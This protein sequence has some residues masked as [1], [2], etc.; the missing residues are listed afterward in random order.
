M[1]DVR[2]LEA[3]LRA[4]RRSPLATCSASR[5]EQSSTPPQPSNRR[6]DDVDLD[7]TQPVEMETEERPPGAIVCTSCGGSQFEDGSARPA[8]PSSR[9]GATTSP[10]HHP[11][12]SGV[13]DKG[14]A[15]RNEDAAMAVVG[16]RAVVVVCDGVTTAPDSDRASLAAARAARDVLASAPTA[17]PGTADRGPLERRR[18][19]RGGEP[20]G[21][22]RRSDARQLAGA[23]VVHVRRRRRGADARHGG[24]VRRLAGVLAAGRRR[25]T[26]DDRPLV[27]TELMRARADPRRGG[28]R[29]DVTHHHAVAR[30]R[31][32]Q[33]HPRDRFGRA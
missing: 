5:A 27:G 22:R 26:A 12:S 4:A 10:S 7:D 30:G 6:P 29:A 1:S 8:A 24:L 23:T 33:P 32:C 18:R 21:R 25:G 11:T 17:P 15:H 28:G 3:V 9:R 19:L 31:Q 13:C 14:V 16:E 20:R 2:T